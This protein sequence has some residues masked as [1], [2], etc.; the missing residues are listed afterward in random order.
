M[1]LKANSQH[2][3]LACTNHSFISSN[4]KCEKAQ[5]RSREKHNENMLSLDSMWAKT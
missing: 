4:R 2:F 1:H 3:S 5:P